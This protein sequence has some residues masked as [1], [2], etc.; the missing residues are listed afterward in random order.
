MKNTVMLL[1][2]L[3]LV[4]PTSFAHECKNDDIEV[5]SDDRGTLI[6]RKGKL[7]QQLL[8]LIDLGMMEKDTDGKLKFTEDADS[9]MRD[10][11]DRGLVEELFIDRGTICA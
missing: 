8:I 1:I 9:L 4:S 7:H 2:V 5:K 3:I 6:V 11:E 10:L